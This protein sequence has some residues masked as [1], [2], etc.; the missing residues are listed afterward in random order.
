[1]FLAA[2]NL[3]VI[4]LGKSQVSL[5]LLLTRNV[6]DVLS[7]NLVRILLLNNLGILYYTHIYAIYFGENIPPFPQYATLVMHIDVSLCDN[8]GFTQNK[9]ELLSFFP[10]YGRGPEMKFDVQC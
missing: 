9:T 1:M 5:T 8:L 7:E 3:H 2:H 6:P 10:K 4:V